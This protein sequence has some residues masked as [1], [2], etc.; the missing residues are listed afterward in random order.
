MIRRPPR[1]TLDRSSAASDVYKRQGW[2][3]EYFANADLQGQPVVVQDDPQI[4]FNWGAGAPAPGVPPNDYSVR[5]TREQ[6]FEQGAYRFAVNV[7]GGVRLWL[8]GQ[9]LIDSWSDQ[10]LRLEQADSPSLASGVHPVRVEYRKRSGN[11]LIAASYNHL[12]SHE[13]VLDIVCRLLL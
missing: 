1:S 8:D 11:G 13:P 4:N 10:G 2:K 5:W 7:E 3:G 12:R 6:A 9:I